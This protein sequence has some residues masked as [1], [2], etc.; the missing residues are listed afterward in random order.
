MRWR[1][2]GRVWAPDGSLP[3]ARSHAMLPTPL[4]LGD[5]RLRLYLACCDAGT[6]SRIGW[7]DVKADDP[8]RV[9]GWAREPVL[10]IG[11]AGCFDDNG[12]NPCSIVALPGGRLRLYYVGYQR[13]GKVPYTLFTGV[14]EADGPDG[15][16]VRVQD[17]PVLDRGPGE[18]FFRTAAL[19]RP[20]PGGWEA[21]YVGGGQFAEAAGRLQPRYGIRRAFSADGLAW[22]ARGEAVLEPAP[23]EIG[24]GRPWVMPR[25]GQAD[26]LWYSARGPRGYRIGHAVREGTGWARRDDAEG[27]D[28]AAEDWDGGMQCYAATQ[29]INGQVVMFYNGDG[30]GRTGLGAAVLEQ[31]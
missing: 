27:L 25:A 7:V 30:Y 14:A 3:W 20:A 26:V 12:V 24:F 10:D 4:P 5:G 8:S 28:G 6:V 2:L 31:G 17:V 13:P 29:D 18:R 15:P 19:V 16:F 21:L 1:R 11:E 23:G 22:P 9:L